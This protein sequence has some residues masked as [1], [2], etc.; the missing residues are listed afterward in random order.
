M[1]LRRFAILLLL[2][3]P[4]MLSSFA[5]QQNIIVKKRFPFKNINYE[6]GLLDNNVNSMATDANGFT[7]ISTFTG[8]QRFNGYKLQTINPVINK[9]TFQVNYP[10]YLFGL[11]DGSV[12]LSIKNGLLKYDT[13]SDKFKLL[14]AEPTLNTFHFAIVPLKETSKGIWCLQQN[15]GIVLYSNEGKLLQQFSFF[16]TDSINNI[17]QTEN[18]LR[19]GIFTTDD[20]SIYIN[21]NHKNILRIN[22]TDN[23]GTIITPKKEF[24]AI[25]CLKRKLYLA[26]LN[27]LQIWNNNN[28]EK[29]K[30]IKLDSAE[31]ITGTA[32]QKAGDDH[33][34][35]SRNGH[36]YLMY[37][38]G[39]IQYELTDRDKNS[40]VVNGNIGTIYPDK[41]NRIWL[42]SNN[43][44]K[45]IE[46]AELLFQ[47]F[48]YPDKQSNFIRALYYDTSKN[49]LLAGGYNGL[50]Q[51]YD[52]S[53]NPL[54]QQAVVTKTGEYILNIEKLTG[55]KYLVIPF[56]K[57]PFIFNI[58]TKKMEALKSESSVNELQNTETNY[59]CNLQRINDSVVLIA[60]KNTV[61]KCIFRKDELVSAI[62][63]FNFI[64]D[65]KLN[66]FLYADNKKLWVGTSNGLLY[67]ISNGRSVSIPVPGNYTVRSMTENST[68]QIYVG[69]E[70]GLLVYNE[71]GALLKKF[72]IASGLRNDCIYAISTEKNNC[73][74]STNLGISSVSPDGTI[75]NYSKEMGLQENEFNTNA[76]LQMKN[77]KIFFGGV[78]GITA[79]YPSALTQVK[80]APLIH[81]TDLTVDDS[82]LNSSSGIW[83][84]D[85]IKLNYKQNRLRFD[86][87]AM[88]M[89]N[90]NEYVYRYRFIWCRYNMAN[91]LSANKY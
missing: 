18:I 80:D 31:T 28:I 2:V 23:T 91:N 54:W 82:S 73:Y 37:A 12:L 41:F 44:I 5:Q 57:N 15:K 24:I 38:D 50:I 21:N 71:N 7:W 87:A 22:T 14:I 70:K 78:N 64:N 8:L 51:A 52:T 72:T 46:N 56:N 79:F 48:A 59:P 89:L 42:L 3:V 27:N 75:H 32:L 61:Y 4:N 67:I 45:R 29:E 69:T 35:L 9:D 26:G 85:A 47:N 53:A 40:F 81:I 63:Q 58:S 68:H 55:D 36:L 16:N 19:E 6:N 33:L 25:S 49:I 10:V 11:M 30:I 62:P 83:F 86:I 76:V 39:N 60:T 1:L 88:G 43:D 90:V 77:G 13:H 65:K 74:V 34:F 20:Q 84:G 17:L 66:C